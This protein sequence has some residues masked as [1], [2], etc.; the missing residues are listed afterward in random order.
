MARLDA[1]LAEVRTAED[2]KRWHSDCDAVEV[3]RDTLAT[4]LRAYP[5]FLAKFTDL[6]ARI[7]N[8]DAALSKLHFARPA[9]VSRHLLGAELVARGL[10]SFS[11]E[12]PSIT[13]ELQLPN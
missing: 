7:A 10:E 4:E 5:E 13:K 8:N 9:G 1:R 3:E 11:R 2:L 12:N 6:L